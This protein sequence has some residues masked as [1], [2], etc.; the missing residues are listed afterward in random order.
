MVIRAFAKSVIH[1]IL[2][3]DREHVA[4]VERLKWLV[5]RTAAQVDHNIRDPVARASRLIDDVQS[6]LESPAPDPEAIAY[7]RQSA[8]AAA[9]YMLFAETQIDVFAGAFRRG[10]GD[11]PLLDGEAPSVCDGVTDLSDVVGPPSEFSRASSRATA[12]P[13]IPW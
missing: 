7:M 9:K 12:G 3:L 5:E 4:A 2:A 1:G 11:R 13:A 10:D 8:D 6:M